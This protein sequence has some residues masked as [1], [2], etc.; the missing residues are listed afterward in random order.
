MEYLTPEVRDVNDNLVVYAWLRGE[1][2]I[3]IDDIKIECYT[4]K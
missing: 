4:K 1:K 3:I 2:E